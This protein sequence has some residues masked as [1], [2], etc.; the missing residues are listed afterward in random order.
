MITDEEAKELLREM[1]RDGQLDL[2]PTSDDAPEYHRAEWCGFKGD[3]DDEKLA[4]PP[5]QP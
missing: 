1:F 3:S 5:K 4:P 2:Y